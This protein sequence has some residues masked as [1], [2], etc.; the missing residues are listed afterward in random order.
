MLL[1]LVI[2]YSPQYTG[3]RPENA[4]ERKH[5]KAHHV[6]DHPWLDYHQ[7]NIRKS[8][9]ARITTVPRPDRWIQE[10]ATPSNTLLQ[11]G[12]NPASTSI[13]GAEATCLT[14]RYLLLCCNAPSSPCLLVRRWPKLFL[15]CQLPIPRYFISQRHLSSNHQHWSSTACI[16]ETSSL[17]E[18]EVRWNSIRAILRDTI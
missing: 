3:K 14:R 1:E 13:Y 5:G 4:E 18:E 16:Q 2:K 10:Q 15:S 6:I 17:I 8:T 12:Y 11:V 9:R 7:L